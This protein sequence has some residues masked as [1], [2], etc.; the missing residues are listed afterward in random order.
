LKSFTLYNVR[1]C[2]LAT[3][4]IAV[5]DDIGVENKEGTLKEFCSP[6]YTK[7]VTAS[8]ITVKITTLLSIIAC[9]QRINVIVWTFIP[10]YRVGMLNIVMV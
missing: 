5:S 2:F 7:N 9:C 10:I 8:P 6:K 4:I 3:I 1:F